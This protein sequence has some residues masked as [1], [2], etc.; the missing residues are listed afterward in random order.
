MRGEEGAVIFR[1][2]PKN[3]LAFR[4][5]NAGMGTGA[6]RNAQERKIPLRVSLLPALSKCLALRQKRCEAYQKRR[7][8]GKDQAYYKKS[9]VKTRMLWMQGKRKSMPRTE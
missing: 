1:V 3:F 7:K 8:S 5:E 2:K 4:Y 6:H 9:K